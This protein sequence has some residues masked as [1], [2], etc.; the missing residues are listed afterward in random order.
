MVASNQIESVTEL[1]H[2]HPPVL[3]FSK[4]E[5]ALQRGLEVLYKAAVT[6][7]VTR[8]FDDIFPEGTLAEYDNPGPFEKPLAAV[9]YVS[10]TKVVLGIAVFVDEWKGQDLAELRE[11]C[12][13]AGIRLFIVDRLS[14]YSMKVFERAVLADAYD[15]PAEVSLMLA[16]KARCPYCGGPF[17][18]HY[19]IPKYKKVPESF[20]TC[21]QYYKDQGVG[22]RCNGSFCSLEELLELYDPRI[23]RLRYQIRSEAR[24]HARILDPSTF[25][26]IP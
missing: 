23:R 24:E 8:Q 17:V 6:V 25:E 9:V 7:E 13:R 15:I 26:P 18:H 21:I 11:F 3:A 19:R 4:T 10:K 12:S 16:T 2:R 20:F 1:R 5:V 22:S 14:V